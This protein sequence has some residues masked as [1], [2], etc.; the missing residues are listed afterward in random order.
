M[1]RINQKGGSALQLLIAAVVLV[2]IIGISWKVW[3]KVIN[4]E[5]GERAEEINEMIV[6]SSANPQTPTASSGVRLANPAS[7]NCLHVGG[8]LMIQQTPNGGQYGVCVFED[9]R[10]CEEWA[11]MRGECPVG[12]VKITGYDNQ[13]EIYCAISGG[14]TT[15]VTNAICKFADG[16]ECPVDQYFD[17]SC[18]SGNKK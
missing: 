8:K 6:K 3:Q 14:Q 7:E 2:M 15:A 16:S 17:G 18:Q 13:A 5:S 1:Q 12:G 4:H 9:N 11:L 10:Q